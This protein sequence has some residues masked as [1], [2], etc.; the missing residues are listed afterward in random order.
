[1]IVLTIVGSAV[2]HMSNADILKSFTVFCNKITSKVKEI[3]N[4]LWA[5]SLV[6]FILVFFP[7]SSFIVKVF[8]IKLFRGDLEICHALWSGLFIAI[9]T[10]A[11]L[12]FALTLAWRSTK[13]L[14]IGWT[15]EG[16]IIYLRVRCWSLLNIILRATCC[17]WPSGIDWKR[18]DLWNCLYS[19]FFCMLLLFF[20]HS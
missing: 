4:N 14:S 16:T 10:A 13:V 7:R 18:I 6:K 19:S 3:V 17:K 12:T 1:M 8:I 11:S 20:C 2:Y 15:H 9:C 5:D